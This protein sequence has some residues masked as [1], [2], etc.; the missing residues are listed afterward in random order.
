MRF[1]CKKLYVG[2][3]ITLL[4]LIVPVMCAAVQLKSETI[5][6]WDAYIAATEKRIAGEINSDYGF[7]ALDFSSEPEKTRDEVL[8][9]NLY[10]IEVTTT[11]DN[12]K[13]I[14]VPGGTIHHWR[15]CVFLPG[16]DLDSYLQ[17]VK[18][19]AQRSPDQP[20]VLELQVLDSTPD[21][22]WL[23]IRMTRTKFVKLTYNSEHYIKYFYHG[24]ARG[25]RKSVSTKIAELVNPGTPEEYEKPEG[26]DR[27][28]MWRLFS[29]W[30]FEEVDGGLIVEGESMLL[31][32]EVPV[33]LAWLIMPLIDRAAHE[34]ITHTLAQ[35][36]ERYTKSDIVRS[37]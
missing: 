26:M 32:R 19:P 13:R 20:E 14:R 15:G 23:Y 12:D 8:N 33:A 11:D 4:T 34:L 28:F 10:V 7:L 6:V 36:K 18:N 17:D 3:C 21:E 31:S 27:G 30:R 29:Y 1:R 22:M 35:M 9:G 24:P 5:E 2:I 37:Q 25:S 16:V